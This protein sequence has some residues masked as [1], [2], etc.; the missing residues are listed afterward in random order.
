MNKY[1]IIINKPYRKE[2]QINIINKFGVLPFKGPI[3]L[4][5]PKHKFW[6]IEDYTTDDKKNCILK[7]VYFGLQIIKKKKGF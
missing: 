7:K 5:E 2:D 4:K 6:I 3:N 1:T